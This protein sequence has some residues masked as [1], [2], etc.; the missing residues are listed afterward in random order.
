MPSGCVYH[1]TFAD[2]N[3]FHSRNSN[4]PLGHFHCSPTSLALKI[5]YSDPKLVMSWWDW[6][7]RHQVVRLSF[8]EVCVFWRCMGPTFL[9]QQG[10][11]SMHLVKYDWF[12]DM[13]YLS[14]IC[15]FVDCTIWFIARLLDW[16]FWCLAFCSLHCD[17]WLRNSDEKILN[18]LFVRLGHDPIGR[19]SD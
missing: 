14:P 13:H 16:L 2:E 5:F 17:P 19:D 15:L 18:W 8:V 6:Q 10:G 1:S 9:E 3:P 4:D 11:R 12:I 7:F